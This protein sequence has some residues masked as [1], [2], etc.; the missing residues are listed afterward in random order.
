MQV[1][2]LG[3]NIYLLGESPTLAMNVC[4]A[5]KWAIKGQISGTFIVAKLGAFDS[6][7]S[8]WRQVRQMRIEKV[9]CTAIETRQWYQGGNSTISDEI[10]SW[11]HTTTWNSSNTCPQSY[12]CYIN[13]SSQIFSVHYKKYLYV[14][15]AILKVFL[16][17]LD[18]LIPWVLCYQACFV[19][20]PSHLICFAKHWSSSMKRR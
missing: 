1:D 16:D 12:S 19:A 15:N 18:R 10:N 5:N 3:V 17:R 2:C 9:T 13:I 11:P 8:D 14:F 6:V 7:G 20:F 4:R